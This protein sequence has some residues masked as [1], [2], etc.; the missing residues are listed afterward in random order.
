MDQTFRDLLAAEI[1]KRGAF[2]VVEA[3]AE[4]LEDDAHDNGE[5]DDKAQ[6]IR[7]VLPL[8]A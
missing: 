1:E 7:R 4:A 5:P 6:A 3:L 8:M 2:A